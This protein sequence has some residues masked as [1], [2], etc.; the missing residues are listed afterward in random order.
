[1]DPHI[2]EHLENLKIYDDYLLYGEIK[3]AF[4]EIRSVQHTA[5]HTRHSINSVPTGSTYEA[6]LSLILSNGKQVRICPPSRPFRSSTSKKQMEAVMKASEIISAITFNQRVERYEQEFMKKKFLR[7]ASYHITGDG[8]LFRNR[9]RLFN[10]LDESN[11]FSFDVFSIKVL[12]KRTGFSRIFLGEEE[13]TIP[14]QRDRDC[15][16]YIL[17]HRLG[18]AFPGVPVREKKVD[19]RK[20]Y[21]E[22]ILRLGAKIAKADGQITKEEIAVFKSIFKIDEES[23]PGAG[24]IFKKAAHSSESIEDIAAEIFTV[25]S[26]NQEMLEYIVLGLI[27]VAKADGVFHAKESSLIRRVCDAF[28]F[29]RAKS[30]S[31]FAVGGVDAFFEDAETGSEERARHRARYAGPGPSDTRTCLRILGL[32]DNASIEEIKAAYRRAARQHHPDLLRARGVPVE[33]IYK[34]EEMLKRINAAY[35]YLTSGH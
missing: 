10:L 29:T 13:Y 9:E 26:D 28:Y 32:D 33:E 15:I 24:D 27:E 7:I 17:K 35:S 1:M 8:N 21:F 4:G 12:R 14:I 6:H 30:L 22:A 16:L 18:F 3:I 34:S 19:H 5:T 31:L 20:I 25:I 23:F 2:I 11:R